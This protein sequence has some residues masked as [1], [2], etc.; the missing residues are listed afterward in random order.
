MDKGITFYDLIVLRIP[1]IAK[2]LTLDELNT[3][4]PPT[5]FTFTETD[6]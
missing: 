4:L 3:I 2:L 1:A 6:Q 5:I